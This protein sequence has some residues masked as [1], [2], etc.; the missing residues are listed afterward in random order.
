MNKFTHQRGDFIK[1]GIASDSEAYVAPPL[2][3]EVNLHE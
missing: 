1:G 2:N 3:D